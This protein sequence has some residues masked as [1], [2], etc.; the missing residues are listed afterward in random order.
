MKD[1]STF[2][3][4]ISVINSLYVYKILS[5][6]KHHSL[7]TSCKSDSSSFSAGSSSACFQHVGM[8]QRSGQ[9]LRFLSLYPLRRRSH[10]GW[11]LS[12]VSIPISPKVGLQLWPFRYLHPTPNVSLLLK[13]L[14]GVSKLTWLKQNSRFPSSFISTNLFLR[15]SS[16]ISAILSLITVLDLLHLINQ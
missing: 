7:N 16:P 14:T 15:S 13:L 1:V 3:N 6:L 4:F 12:F 11:W 10:P 8:P 5:V 9:T 2:V